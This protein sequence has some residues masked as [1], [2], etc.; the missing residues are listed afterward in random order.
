[1]TLIQNPTLGRK[2]QR[3]LRLTGLPDSILAPEIVGVVLLEDLSAPLSDEERGCMGATVRNS[4]VGE[5]SIIVLTRVGAPAGYDLVVTE[6]HFSTQTAQLIGIGLPTAGV[7][8]LTPVVDTSFVDFGIPGRPT[9]QLGS[10]TQ[11]GPPPFRR[12]MEFEVLAS[13]T[14]IIPVNIRIGTIGDG[15][16]FT[17][18]MIHCDSVNTSLAGGFKWVESAPQG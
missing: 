2:L 14:Y 11:V 17:S 15:N 16:D 4:V 10:D 12:L 18:L 6:V 13:V 3:S 1:M 5:N 7:L 9:S 8:G